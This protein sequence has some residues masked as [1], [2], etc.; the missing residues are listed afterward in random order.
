MTTSE[1]WKH[2]KITV[3]KQLE[4]CLNLG[5]ELS[6]LGRGWEYED[7]KDAYRVME[8]YGIVFEDDS[9]DYEC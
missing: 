6:P 9:E 3:Q 4:A 2:G 7:D 8:Y 1:V 5:I